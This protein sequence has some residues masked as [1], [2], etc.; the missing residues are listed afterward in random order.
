MDVRTI[1]LRKILYGTDNGKLCRDNKKQFA[2]QNDLALFSNQAL[3]L[4]AFTVQNERIQSE[5]Q[6]IMKR[7]VELES[8][9]EMQKDTEERFRAYFIKIHYNI[10]Q[11]Q[12]KG[13]LLQG[14]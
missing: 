7:K 10:A 9:L 11:P 12:G 8:I 14:A 6:G 13:E 1:A 2:R 4:D 5:Q 3:T